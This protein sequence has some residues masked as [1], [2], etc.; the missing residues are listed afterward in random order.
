MPA[1]QDTLQPRY[2]LTKGLTNRLM[3]QDGAGGAGRSWMADF[4][5]EFLP[6]ELRREYGS[7]PLA[8]G[9]EKDPLS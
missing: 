8:G 9:G 3:I 1:V 7:D 4:W 6:E 2:A 5:Q